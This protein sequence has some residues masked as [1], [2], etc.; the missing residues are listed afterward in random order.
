MGK[1]VS[2]HVVTDSGELSH[3]ERRDAQFFTE[4]CP[5]TK[6]YFKAT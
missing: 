5:G 2:M 4:I 1:F 6:F 3:M